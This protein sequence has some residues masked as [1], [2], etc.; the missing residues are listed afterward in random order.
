MHELKEAIKEK[1]VILFVGAGVSKNLGLPT[2]SEL[3]NKIAEELGFEPEIFTSMADNM[4]LAEYYI[5]KKGIGPLRSW[6]DVN[7]HTKDKSIVATNE[8]YTSIVNLDFPIIYTT[9]YDRWIE[10]AFD[11]KRKE[12]I[13]I[14]DVTNIPSIV[15]SKTQ[16]IK[17][18]G[19]FEKDESIVLSE[20]S[21]FERLNFESPLDIKLRS[22]VLGKSILF[23]GY[24]LSDI[25]MR[26]LIYRLNKL[27][28]SSKS[29]SKPKSYIFLTR[30]NPVQEVI[31]ES[32][33]IKPIVSESDD[34]N[35]GLKLFLAELLK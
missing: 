22:D 4:E 14:I 26:L 20:S 29:R 25:N 28:A 12:Y 18:H 9:N 13:K 19:D 3:I 11:V 27:W 35:E 32:R 17:F 1:K 16:I 31:F 15:D 30:P 24:S 7:W 10:N 33:G 21:Y 2:W 8:I 5:I 34:A 6:M 23:I